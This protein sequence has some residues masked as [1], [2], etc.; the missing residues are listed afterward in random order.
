MGS[1]RQKICVELKNSTNIKIIYVQVRQIY[2]LG[3][4][5]AAE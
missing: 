5:G 1:L 2:S 3:K 4:M